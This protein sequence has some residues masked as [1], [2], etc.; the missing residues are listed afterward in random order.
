MNVIT[1]YME[2]QK[3]LKLFALLAKVYFASIVI[4]NGIRVKLSKIY[5]YKITKGKRCEE[6]LEN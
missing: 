6:V 2:E 3:I 4:L 1:L 5:L